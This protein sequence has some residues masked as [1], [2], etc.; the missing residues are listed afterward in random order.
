LQQNSNR[1]GEPAAQQN[2]LSGGGIWEGS[3]LNSF[4]GLNGVSRLLCGFLA[5]FLHFIAGRLWKERS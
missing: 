2:F 5:R 4:E 1:I 3:L